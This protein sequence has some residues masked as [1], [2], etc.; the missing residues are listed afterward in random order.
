M[1]TASLFIKWDRY[2]ISKNGRHFADDMFK[3]IWKWF[4]SNS[5]VNEMYSEGH[6]TN[7][8]W[9]RWCRH[10]I[11][12][13]KYGLVYRSIYIVCVTQP[14]WIMLSRWFINPLTPGNVY[15]SSDLTII[16]KYNCYLKRCSISANWTLRNKVQLNLN[17]NIIM[18]VHRCRYIA[19]MNFNTLIT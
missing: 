5:N 7:V 13:T 10:A 16:I 3:F 9:F 11:N 19:A 18:Y 1:K 15:A 4:Y 12:C 6:I 17:Q 8:H 2:K 14:R